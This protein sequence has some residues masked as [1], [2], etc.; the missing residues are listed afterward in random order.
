MKVQ[1]RKNNYGHL[2]ADCPFCDEFVYM[3]ESHHHKHKPDRLSN[4]K[5]HIIN[6]AR[7]EA[8]ES[9]LGSLELGKHL[10]YIKDHTEQKVVKIK[11]ARQFDSDLQ[12]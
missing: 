3:R 8:F 7:N 1:T 12:I 6:K 11:D 9:A 2:V 4:L 5:R 10:A